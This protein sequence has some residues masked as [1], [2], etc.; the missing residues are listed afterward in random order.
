MKKFFSIALATI[1]V[2]TMAAC[3]GSTNSSSTAPSS[4]APDGSSTSEVQKDTPKKKLVVGTSA[5]FAPYE[6]HILENGKDKIV[7]FDIALAQAIADDL[8]AELEIKDM[9]FDSILIELQSGTIDLAIAGLSPDPERLNAVDMSKPYYTGGQ[10]FIINV[11]DAEKYK[12]L[13]QMNQAGMSIGAQTGS[14]Q[15][16]LAMEHTPNATMVGLQQ[17]PSIIM[18]LKSGKI[19]GAFMETVIAENYIKTQ[20]DIMIM[21]EV[22]YD[23]EGSCVAVKK[24]NTELLDAVNA[25]IDKVV[26]NGQMAQ[27]IEDANNIA[28]QS[29]S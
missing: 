5:D 2:A 24:G 1:M 12:T 21:S 15:A 11:K 13:E 14:I 16:K 28:D 10:S 7:G 3:G 17:I 19:N 8:G 25:T 20:S 4:T 27:F 22:P 9:S 29:I 23:A 26:S 18:E 6:F